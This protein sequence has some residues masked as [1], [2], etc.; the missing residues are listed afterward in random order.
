MRSSTLV[1]FTFLPAVHA[2]LEK[3][4]NHCM[5]TLAPLTNFHINHPHIMHCLKAIV[6]LETHTHIYAH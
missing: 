4:E 3:C 5:C 1:L 6:K 2:R